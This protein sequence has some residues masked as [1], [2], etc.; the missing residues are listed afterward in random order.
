T[1]ERPSAGDDVI[2]LRLDNGMLEEAH[3]KTDGQGAFTL[4][5]QFADLPHVVRVLHQ[6]VNYDHTVTGKTRLEIKVFDSSAKVK[7]V[8]GYISIVK[9]ESDGKNFNIT[10]LH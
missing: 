6:G 5:V 2:L 8:S 3:A 4:N 10:E 9:V 7:G 1:T